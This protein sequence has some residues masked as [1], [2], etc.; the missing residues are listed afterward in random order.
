MKVLA[1]LND[2]KVPKEGRESSST[3]Y[4]STIRYKHVLENCL[5]GCRQ[6]V[7]SPGTALMQ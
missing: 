1:E 2:K 7:G 4:F 3:C 5:K 6:L